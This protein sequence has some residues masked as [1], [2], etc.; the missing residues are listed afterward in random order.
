LRQYWWPERAQHR[1]EERLLDNRLHSLR[2][3]HRKLAL[4]L[5]LGQI[6]GRDAAAAQRLPQHIGGDHRVLNGQVDA[7]AG[8]W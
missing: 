5:D 1:L 7:D 2:D 6:P 3:P 4:T 8:D